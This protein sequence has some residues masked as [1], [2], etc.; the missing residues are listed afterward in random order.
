MEINDSLPQVYP[1]LVIN[2]SDS[3]RVINVDVQSRSISFLS[4]TSTKH[5]PLWVEVLGNHL[6][7]LDDSGLLWQVRLCESLYLSAS[8]QP[9]KPRNSRRTYSSIR[10]A[11]SNLLAHK[12]VHP[13]IGLGV[14]TT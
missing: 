8:L 14:S 3:S 2:M 7:R 6:S 10:R 4:Q 12:L 5:L 9:Q 11:L 1:L 13:L